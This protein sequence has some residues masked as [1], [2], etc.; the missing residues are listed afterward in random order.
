MIGKRLED[1]TGED[2]AALITGGVAEG[3]TIEYKREFPGGSD[4]DKKEFLADSSS[5]ANSGG[6]DLVFGMEESQGL[7]TQIVGV[8]SGDL[9]LEIGRLDSVLAAGLD[10]RI[11]YASKVVACAG[12]QKA[13]V[14][15][16]ENSWSGPHR[17]VF[18]GHDKFYGRNSAGKYPL[19]VNE[20]RAAFTL[21][22]TVTE[23]IRA[24]RIDRI[25][26]LSNNQT[27]VPFVTTPR[28]VL[29][30]I[31]IQSFADAKSY[32]VI[33]VYDKP[34]ALRPM[35]PVGWDRRLNLDGVVTFAGN[36]SY[37]YTQ[38]Y[39]NGAIEAVEGRLFSRKYQDKQ[40]IAP[41]SYERYVTEYL[42]Y[43][44]QLLRDL[45][46]N[47]P[48]VVALSLVQTRGLQ[49]VTET[50]GYPEFGQ[51]IDTDTLILPETVVQ[52]LSTPA[53]QIL[54]PIFDLVW[55]ASGFPRSRNF[56]AVGNWIGLT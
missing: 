51:T 24:F 46:P 52:E 37:S 30:C 29:H 23:H 33:S 40:I 16:V 34:I 41:V 49:L 32:D 15:R 25:I 12:N 39:R 17:V 45:G 43:C 21:S 28:I 5:F 11:R 20:L 54:R 1:I 56:D 47:A 53:N 55:N 50:R 19:D 8:Q 10:P 4:G 22:E 35:A 36:P 2:L 18:K 13:L 3:R 42:T 44:F 31:P 14:L 38:V 26:A 48:I 7:P 6:G 9:D 27:P